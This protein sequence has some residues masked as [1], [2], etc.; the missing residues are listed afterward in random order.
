MVWRSDSGVDEAWNGVKAGSGLRGTLSWYD[1]TSWRDPHGKYAN[2]WHGLPLYHNISGFGV[3][4]YPPLRADS[5]PSSTSSEAVGMAILPSIRHEHLWLGIQDAE[6]FYLLQEAEALPREQFIREQ[7]EEAVAVAST[8]PDEVLQSVWNFTV[9][10]S[11][12]HLLPPIPN[13]GYTINVTLIREAQRKSIEALGT[14]A[15]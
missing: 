11:L 7:S 4:L 6:A 3:Q 14:A 15:A 9:E 5:L 8:V 2:P 13:D 12:Q 1:A 10:W